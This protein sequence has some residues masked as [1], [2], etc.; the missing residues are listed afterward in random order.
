MAEKP[1]EYDFHSD[2]S[3]PTDGPGRKR[4][5]PRGVSQF[6][7]S[8]RP[9]MVL[10]AVVLVSRLLLALLV[11]PDTHR[12]YNGDSP[13]YEQYA[14]SMLETGRYL[15]PGYGSADTNPFA[16]MIRPPGYPLL[17]AA[18]YGVVGPAA[19][20]WVLFGLN[21]LAMCGVLALLLGLLRRLKL[22]RAWPMLLVIALDPAWWMYSKELVPEPWFVLLLTASVLAVYV[23]VQ[24]AV[25][26]GHPAEVSGLRRAGAALPTEGAYGVQRAVA[27]N[28]SPGLPDRLPVWSLF[29]LGG[30]A[31]GLATWFKPITLYAPWLALPALTVALWYMGAGKR[32]PLA[33]SALYLAGAMV[34]I[35]SWQLRNYQQHGSLAYTSIA[36]EN[37]LTGHA[38]FVLAAREGIT[39]LEAQ[40]RIRDAY[41]R[42]YGG[43]PQL[44]TFAGEEEAK[45]T[46]AREILAENRLLYV[47]TIV[48]GMV[49]TLMDPGRLVFTR[50]F[51]EPDNA[52]IGLTNTLS[53]EG[54][55][56]TVRILLREDPVLVVYAVAYMLFLGVFAMGSLVGAWWLGRRYPLLVLMLVA[57]VLYLWILGGPSGYARFRLYLMPFMVVLAS[58]LYL[59]IFPHA[60]QPLSETTHRPGRSSAREGHQ[61]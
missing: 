47:R 48:R 55:L 17:L 44:E 14:L 49:V 52:Q 54:L 19:G 32:R 13:L 15:S 21:T 34:F 29:L 60:I 23:G 28:E 8:M 1:S 53:R 11:W 38:A 45:R 61:G 27:R 25:A 51:R 33:L 12:L 50:T 58:G 42:R 16:D 9:L 5:L 30:L 43:T 40:Q 46:L 20:P 2:A 6:F 4:L 31:L 24:R 7:G 39:H 18:V 35:F 26:G 36:A 41:A 22:D 59:R 10:I 3:D 56:G 57:A 37:M